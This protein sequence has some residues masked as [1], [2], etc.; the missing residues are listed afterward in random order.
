MRQKPW[1][2]INL[3][4]TIR[5]KHP[6]VNLYEYHRRFYLGTG[7]IRAIGKQSALDL[8]LVDTDGLIN[9]E[10]YEAYLQS[11]YPGVRY[12]PER[13]IPGTVVQPM[14]TE[15][16]NLLKVSSMIIDSGSYN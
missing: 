6:G 4:K 7:V 13:P 9:D 14:S 8:G 1:E 5:K 10:A 11:L 12:I 3:P 2:T 15:L 16:S